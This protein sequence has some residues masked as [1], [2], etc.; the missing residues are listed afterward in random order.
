MRGLLLFPLALTVLV[1]AR[2]ISARQSAVPPSRPA[3]PQEGIF[4]VFPF[5]NAGAT[6]R[7][8]WIGEGLEELTIQRLSAA[9]QQ[10]YSHAGRV[11]EMD[12]YG[13]PSAARLSR[14]TMLHIAQ[15][16]DADYIIFG[17]FTSDG[18]NLTVDAR[19]L[20]ISPVSLFPAVRET[21]PLPSLMDLHNRLLWRLLHAADPSFPLALT[22]FSKLQRP[23]SLAAFEQYIRGLLANDD[24]ARLRALKEAAR[25]EPDWP[26]PAFAIGETYFQHNDCNS[27]L[28]WF[29]KVPPG[30]PQNVE[31]TFAIGVCRLRQGQP[32]RAEEVFATLQEDLHRNLISGADLPEILNNLGIARARQDNLPAAL[33]VISRAGDIDP[34]EDDYPFNLGLL[35]L[36]QKEYARASTHFAEATKREPENPEDRAFLIYSLEKDGKKSEATAAREAAVEIL[37]EKGLP[38]LKFDSKNAD[39][40][41]KYQRVMR[42][43]DTTSLRL[44]LEGPQK[45]QANGDAVVAKDG[46]IAHL[47]KGRLELIAGRLDVAEIEFKAALAADPHNASAH[48]ELAEIYRRRGKLDDAAHELQLS[49]AERDS[50]AVHTM[51]AH[52]Y[53]EQHKPDL[54][55]AE[56]EKAVKLAPNYTDAKELLNH[57]NKNKPTGGAP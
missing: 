38:L 11:N 44:E 50:A 21:G 23:L 15:E 49:L 53:L 57:L 25:L 17:S 8:D 3:I 37:G 26:D 4:L 13:L 16:L 20:R 41:T 27:A 14:A 7:L 34:D 6:P 54:A 24:D 1:G 52:I 28:P 45:Q 46:S 36:Q 18:Q 35:A 10:V 2:T 12:V 5:E 55:R 32:E 56:A 43:L 31:A 48:H 51:L 30:H 39:S 19:V 47:R 42:Q 40:L 22:D 29:S 33:T 9:G